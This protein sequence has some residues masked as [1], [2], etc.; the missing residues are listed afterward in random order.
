[1][2]NLREGVEVNDGAVKVI[3]W[4]SGA[5][6][7]GT[8]RVNGVLPFIPAAAVVQGAVLVRYV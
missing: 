2:A 1:M 7:T 5:Q 8:T 6:P 3:G 4:A